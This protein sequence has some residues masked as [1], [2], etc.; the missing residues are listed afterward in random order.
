M[1]C[2][3]VRRRVSRRIS[4]G[5]SPPCPRRCWP[6]HQPKNPL[7][8]KVALVTGSTSGIGLGIARAF[9]AAGHASMLNGFGDRPRT[10]SDAHGS[11][12]AETSGCRSAYSAPTCPSPPRSREMVERRSTAF[13]RVDVLVNNAGIQH[14]APIE[15]FPLAK[16]DA[17]IAI[18]LSSAFHTIAPAL[19]LM[20]QRKL[21]PHHQ[22]R[23]GA[24]PG[25]LAVQVGLCRGQARHRRPD[26][27]GGARDCRARH[28]LQRHL[29]RLC[30]DAAGREADPR[31]RP[32]R[33]GI[34][35]RAVIRDVLLAQQPNK[36]VRHVEQ[37]GALRRVPVPR[38]RRVD[39]RHRAAGRRRLDRAMTASGAGR[40]R[41]RPQNHDRQEDAH[42]S[43]WRRPSSPSA[44]HWT[45]ARSCWSCRAAARSAPIRPA[46]IRRCTRP[47]S[48][49]TG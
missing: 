20:K 28:H 5:G 4:I 25:R 30:A 1:G 15:D 19:P 13:G 47:A 8:G 16:W 10:S 17:I 44:P 29:P 43:Q 3:S 14:V 41:P 46:S 27:D 45:W 2:H 26:Q 11:S 40:T 23:L 24:R 39:H 22:H 35:A 48:S 38:R 33:A 18:N 37:I 49:R 36:R 42:A 32:R 7:A 6:G 12:I 9:A 31:A 21:R 34:T